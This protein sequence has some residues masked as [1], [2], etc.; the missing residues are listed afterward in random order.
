MRLP[1]RQGRTFAETDGI[2]GVPVAL[3]NESF[4][5]KH[6]PRDSALGKDVRLIK[7]GVAQPWLTVVGVVP[8]VLQNFRRPLEH[9]PLIYLPYAQEPQR[10]MFLVSLTAVEPGTLADAV[11]REVQ[12]IDPNLALYDV[13]TLDKRLAEARFS[14]TLLGTMFSVFAGI[15]LVLAAIGLYA[16][17]AH[18][19][20]QRIQEIGIRVAM[21]GSRADIFRLIY[22]QGM[23]PVWIGIAIGLPAAA[24]IARVLRMALVGVSPGDPLTLVLVVLTLVAASITGCAVP[25]RRAVRVDP[26]V[27]LR[28][29]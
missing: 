5:Q 19:V 8:D 20:S 26:I 9:E 23:R 27:A 1:A 15:A 10:D 11:R 4:T 18:S 29:E 22:A 7:D 14:T 21:G 3:V 16:V 24:A 13:R 28:Y 6:W 2:A 17:I 25:A 12:G